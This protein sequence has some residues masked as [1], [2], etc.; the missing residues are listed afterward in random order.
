ML[1]S[2]LRF[3][4]QPAFYNAYEY[5]RGQKLGV[6]RLNTVISDRLARDSLRS[7]IH[8]RHLP[9][10]VKPKPWLNYDD[11]GYIYNKSEQFSLFWSATYLNRVLHLGQAMRFKDS[12][13]QELYLKEATNA[14]TVEL[15]YAGLDVLGSTPWRINKAIFDVV[16]T[17]WNSGERMGKL[18]PAVY[19]QPEPEPPENMDHDLEARSHHLMRQKAWAQAKANTHSERCNVNYKVEIARAVSSFS[20]SL[21]LLVFTSF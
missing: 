6:L 15:V 20:P 17:V 16:V 11:G 1:N 5:Q 18:P 21:C 3:E 13:E 8:P 19:E 2:L 9:M 14:G 12:S 7:T 4:E 10:L